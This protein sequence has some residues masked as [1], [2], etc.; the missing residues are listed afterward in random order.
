MMLTYRQVVLIIELSMVKKLF[1]HFKIYR[2]WKLDIVNFKIDRTWK[3]DIVNV[4]NNIHLHTYIVIQQFHGILQNNFCAR[5]S[6]KTPC[7]WNI[8]CVVWTGLNLISL[9]HLT[10]TPFSFTSCIDTI[11]LQQLHQGNRCKESVKIYFMIPVQQILGH[12]LDNLFPEAK[13]VSTQIICRFC[14]RCR[15]G[16]SF[17][18]IAWSNAFLWTI[19]CSHLYFV[20]LTNYTISHSS[21]S[22]C[23]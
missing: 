8:C 1:I 5:C 9:A 14:S 20:F 22:L 2:T 6:T 23:Q 3:L 15:S 19:S 11:F 4:F 16:L 21:C 18:C 7:T 12:G 10:S 17:R 13:C